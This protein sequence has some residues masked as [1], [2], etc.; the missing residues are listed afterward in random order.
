VRNDTIKRNTT[1]ELVIEKVLNMITDGELKVGDRLPPAHKLAEIFG[2]GRSS[3]REAVRALSVLGYLEILPGKGTF[4]RKDT[5]FEKLSVNNGLI[6]IL[7]SGPIFDIM[8]TRECLECKCAELASVRADP[9]QQKK[10]EHLIKI[11]QDNRSDLETINK[12]DLEFHLTLAEATNNDV[13]YEIMKLLIEKV[14]L[15]ADKFWATL[16][17]TRGKAISTANQVFYHVI[18]GDSKEAAQSMR[19]HLELV[20]DKLKDVISEGV[21]QTDQKSR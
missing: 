13:I 5:S 21:V 9:A 2:V 4:V 18:K 7:E 17:K 20:K 16:P 1:A 15:Y 11:M 8:E 10:M 14:E 3:I 12:A 19:E 6:N